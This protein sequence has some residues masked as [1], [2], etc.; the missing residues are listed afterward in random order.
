MTKHEANIRF[1]NA[2][3]SWLRFRRPATLAEYTRVLRELCVY[4]EDKPLASVSEAEAERYVQHCRA[5][6][7]YNY[8]P[9]ASSTVKRKL[10]QLRSAWNEFE[11][12]GLVSLNPWHVVLRRMPKVP[13]GE[14]KRPLGVIPYNLVTPLIDHFPVTTRSGLRNRTLF[15]LLFSGGLRIDEAL[16][17]TLADVKQ[18]ENGIVFVRLRQTKNGNTYDQPLNDWAVPVLTELMQAR[19]REGAKPE[20]YLF[21]SYATRIIYNKKLTHQAATKAFKQACE[22]VGVPGRPSLHWCRATAITKL[23][24]DGVNHRDVQQFS[25]HSS[26]AQVEVYDKRRRSLEENPGLK[27]SYAASNNLK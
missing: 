17:L 25:R 20:H 26:I 15:S 2:L 12:L 18:T 1:F 19:L 16:S 22:A 24:D 13:S 14:S 23:L 11:R 21:V 9:A 4:L 3:D 5:K 27:L 8:G 6:T 10:I 7:W